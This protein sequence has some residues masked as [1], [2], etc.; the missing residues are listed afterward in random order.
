MRELEEEVGLKP[1]QYTID[2][3]NVLRLKSYQK[4]EGAGSN[5]AFTHYQIDLFPI[6]LNFSG[7]K[8][9]L[10][11]ENLMGTQDYKLP[12]NLSWFSINDLSLSQNK[13]NVLL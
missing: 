7:V 6:E 2:I 5:H 11:M 12:G 3:D 1:S 4:L 8:Q 13:I 10:T 9:I